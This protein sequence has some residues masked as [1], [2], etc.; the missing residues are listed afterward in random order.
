MSLLFNELIRT[1]QQATLFGL[2]FS[3]SCIFSRATKMIYFD[4]PRFNQTSLHCTLLLLQVE[5]TCDV[6]MTRLY[7]VST[8]GRPLLL[9]TTVALFLLRPA[10]AETRYDGYD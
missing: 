6:D 5:A 10:A 9:V 4:R 1:Q 3:R 2:A 7:E 8:D